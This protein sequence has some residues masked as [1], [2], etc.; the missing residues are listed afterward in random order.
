MTSYEDIYDHE[1]NGTRYHI[2][3]AEIKKQDDT[4]GYL[5]ALMD[6][7]GVGG[8]CFFVPD[9]MSSVSWD[10]VAEKMRLGEADA[11][12]IADYINEYYKREFALVLK[13]PATGE[14]Q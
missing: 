5:F 1:T 4:P 7:C 9:H 8:T 3:A 6:G 2:M 11:R 13:K 12:V 14:L 10:Y